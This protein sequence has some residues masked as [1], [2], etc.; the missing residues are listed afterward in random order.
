MQ[1]LLRNETFAALDTALAHARQF[2][3]LWKRARDT[4][5]ESLFYTAPLLDTVPM[6]F[7]GYTAWDGNMASTLPETWPFWC[8]PNYRPVLDEMVKDPRWS[9]WVQ[10]TREEV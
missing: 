7:S 9:Q 2:D 1:C 8:F 6:D 3:S 4:Q 10:K 5:A